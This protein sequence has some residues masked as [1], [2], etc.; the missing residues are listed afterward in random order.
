MPTVIIAVPTTARTCTPHRGTRSPA[1]HNPRALTYPSARMIRAND[2]STLAPWGRLI[3]TRPSVAPA[4]K[5]SAAHRAI[6]RRVATGARTVTESERYQD[7]P[8]PH[9]G[10]LAEYG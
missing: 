2:S 10:Q 5:S 1:H 4:A 7:Q 9:I 8:S 6:S 3:P